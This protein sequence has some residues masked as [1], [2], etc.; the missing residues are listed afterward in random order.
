MSLP[1]SSETTGPRRLG[2]IAPSVG[3]EGGPR[4]GPI[5]CAMSPELVELARERLLAAAHPVEISKAL[6]AS[7]ERQH[8][9]RPKYR[10]ASGGWA[11]AVDENPDFDGALQAVELACLPAPKDR[12]LEELVKTRAQCVVKDGDDIDMEIQA[13]VYADKLAEYPADCA[14]YVLRVWPSQSKCWPSWFELEKQLKAVASSRT[15]L[16]KDIPSIDR[17]WRAERGIE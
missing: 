11:M 4:P 14:L 9:L 6:R 17:Q 15:V 7:L 10:T 5:A 12:I 8:G 1:K 3:S 16:L 2:E 13:A